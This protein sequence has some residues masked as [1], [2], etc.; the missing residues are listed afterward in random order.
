M[1][2][3]KKR[4]NSQE[5]IKPNLQFIA[6]VN[7]PTLRYTYQLKLKKSFETEKNICI[8]NFTAP[9]PPNDVNVVKR[10]NSSISLDWSS[11]YGAYSYETLWVDE[12]DNIVGSLRTE[13][14][15]TVVTSLE[16]GEFYYLIVESVGGNETNI[17][18]KN[19]KLKVQTSE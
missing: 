3:S 9:L 15:N 6:W 8:N 18:R 10:T 17:Y 4:L 13:D 2:F 11:M 19:N 12:M 7:I 14:N 5:I 1:K 16:A